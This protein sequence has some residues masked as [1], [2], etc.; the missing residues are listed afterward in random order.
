MSNITTTQTLEIQLPLGT[1]H[2]QGLELPANL[3]P[4][5][6]AEQVMQPLKAMSEKIADSALW[7]WGDA[8]AYRETTYG[9]TYDEAEQFSGY[10]NQT[11]R[12][13]AVVC[14]KIEL[15][16]R[17]NNLSFSHHHDIASAFDDPTEQDAWMDKA[18]ENQWSRKD[19]R[20]AIRAAKAEFKGENEISDTADFL[21]PVTAFKKTLLWFEAQKPETWSERQK[22]TW[23]EDLRK[24]LNLVSP[25]L[26]D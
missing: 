9:T 22:Q 14:R 11:L 16:R 15:F 13:V 24:F 19:L 5:V 20:L 1:V 7:W 21:R 8:L 12:Q 4:S 6:F 17:R 23:R 26:E 2:R 3:A 10:A 18:E 25:I